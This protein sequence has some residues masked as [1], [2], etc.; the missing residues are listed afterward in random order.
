MHIG[1][2]GRSFGDRG[3]LPIR[4]TGPVSSVLIYVCDRPLMVVCRQARGHDFQPIVRGFRLSTVDP[5]VDAIGPS[6]RSRL[7]VASKVTGEAAPGYKLVVVRRPVHTFGGYKFFTRAI[8]RHR[9]NGN[10]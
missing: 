10:A 9:G 2:V 8:G 5:L 3:T 1:L 7:P 6:F 4:E